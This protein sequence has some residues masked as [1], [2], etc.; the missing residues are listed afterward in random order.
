MRPLD[1]KKHQQ[2]RK[3]HYTVEKILPFANLL[4]M[5]LCVVAGVSYL[6]AINHS[7]TMTLEAGKIKEEINRLVEANRDLEIQATNLRSIERIKALSGSELSMISVGKY[8]YLTSE[9]PVVVAVKR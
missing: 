7:D 8:E 5:I 4:I 6:L 3:F 9:N 1:L 2:K